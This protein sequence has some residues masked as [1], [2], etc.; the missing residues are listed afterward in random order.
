LRA[1]QFALPIANVIMKWR[2]FILIAM[3]GLS[4]YSANGRSILG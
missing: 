4:I 3:G 2:F 1:K